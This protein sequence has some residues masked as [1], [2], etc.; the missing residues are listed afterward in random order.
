[1][2]I[3][4]IGTLG[5]ANIIVELD[6]FIYLMEVSKDPRERRPEEERR[7]PLSVPHRQT[8]ACQFTSCVLRCTASDGLE[9][10]GKQGN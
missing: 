6:E 1:M 10:P 7:C 3:R 2:W 5:Q 9:F 8:V 4:L